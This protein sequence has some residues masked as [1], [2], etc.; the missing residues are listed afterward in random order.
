MEHSGHNVCYMP[1]YI[2]FLAGKCKKSEMFYIICSTMA[3]TFE[4]LM[5][6][7]DLESF[8][9]YDIVYLITGI[10]LTVWTWRSRKTVGGEGSLN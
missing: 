5:G 8:D 4:P 7:Q 2:L 1:S 10:S 6:L 3:I 9:H